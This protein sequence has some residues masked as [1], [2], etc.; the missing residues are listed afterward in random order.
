[1]LKPIF[2]ISPEIN[3]RIAEIERIKT[4]VDHSNIL[5]EL[6]INLRFRAT[7][8]AIHSST[9]IEGNPLNKDQVEKV[10]KGKLITAPEYAIQEV[11]NYK[12]ALDWID[13]RSQLRKQICKK[14]ILQLHQ[15][16][17]NNLLPSEKIGNWRPGKVYIVD[18]IDNKEIIQYT[19]PI[20]RNISQLIDH[21]LQWLK[22]QSNGNL[23]PV[24]VAGI[25]HFVFVS[26]HP[27]S[28]GNGRVTRLLVLMYLRQNEYG[29]RNALTP[30]SYYL[31]HRL[32]YYKALSLGKTYATRIKADLT[33]FLDYFT[34]GF[35]E[36]VQKL[37]QDITA[38]S[39]TAASKSPIRLS[40]NEIAILDYT[41]RFRSITVQDVI[42]AFNLP[43]RTAQ[44]RLQGLVDKKILKQ[45]GQARATRYIIRK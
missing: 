17:M 28:D 5:P 6:E 43:K 7:V 16:T 25:L 26:I 12:K 35:L 31:Q 19:G 36:V 14:D 13:K 38:A 11:V 24:L 41:R 4:L 18:E 8:D 22:D 15:L 32:Q 23:H 42:D 33:P 29:F 39:N 40:Q 44:R 1:M 9:T 20:A 30:D 37:Q 3:S 45:E 27:F 21:L 10:L 34:K 2:T